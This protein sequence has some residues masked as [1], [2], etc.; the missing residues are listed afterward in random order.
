MYEIVFN[1]NIVDA[2]WPEYD[3]K[4]LSSD[5]I[6]L[7]IQINGKMKKTILITRGEEEKNI[8]DKI[9]VEYPNLITGD[10]KKVIYVPDKII[11]IIL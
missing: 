10:I 5:E 4:Y 8:I 3:S 7:P 2:K 1:E 11:N 6:N 9:K